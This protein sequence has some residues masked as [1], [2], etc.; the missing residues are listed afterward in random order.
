MCCCRPPVDF[1]TDLTRWHVPT[2]TVATGPARLCKRCVQVHTEEQY[3]AAA[4]DI[5]YSVR[6]G[7][8][9]LQDLWVLGST[10]VRKLWDLDRPCG[11]IGAGRGLQGS[12]GCHLCSRCGI[13][14]RTGT[15]LTTN[16]YVC[17]CM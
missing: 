15:L 2:G 4:S 12:V 6:V 14:A 7:Y 9:I 3:A 5:L 17:A 1:G 16:P 11:C 8:D 10:M 13:Q